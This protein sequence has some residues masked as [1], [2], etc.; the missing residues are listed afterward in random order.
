MKFASIIRIIGTYYTTAEYR[1]Q[2]SCKIRASF[3]SDFRIFGTYVI[4]TIHLCHDSA[5]QLENRRNP[6]ESSQAD[7]ASKFPAYAAD[8]C[9]KRLAYADA[10]VVIF[11]PALCGYESGREGDIHLPPEPLSAL[12]AQRLGE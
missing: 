4:F 2:G 12:A 7:R 5:Y 9:A 1:S 8:G 6:H 3:A 11:R 10:A